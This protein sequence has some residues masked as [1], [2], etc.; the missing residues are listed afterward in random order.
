M[1]VRNAVG[2]TRPRFEAA[3]MNNSKQCS[4]SILHPATATYAY[5]KRDKPCLS[6][7]VSVK[8]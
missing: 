2:T 4:T 6:A 5:T 3:A 8:L 7:L 1:R